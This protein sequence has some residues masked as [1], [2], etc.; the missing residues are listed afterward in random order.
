V[1]A[2]GKLS[3]NEDD[4]AIRS[5]WK[6][7]GLNR[8][9][10]AIAIQDVS[11]C[12]IAL[13][14]HLP[15]EGREREK[16]PVE[17]C[18]YNS[19]FQFSKTR[20]YRLRSAIAMN[21][22]RLS[23]RKKRERKQWKHARINPALDIEYQ[24][25]QKREKPAVPLPIPRR[26]RGFF[27]RFFASILARRAREIGAFHG[28]CSHREI[29][30]PEIARSLSVSVPGENA[31]RVSRAADKAPDKATGTLRGDIASSPR[32]E[33]GESLPLPPAKKYVFSVHGEEWGKR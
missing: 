2:L 5:A 27:A 26:K 30:Y 10:A 25:R 11:A 4:G 13:T 20:R 29:E 21:H 23:R 7:Q 14:I 3:A 9:H 16:A 15:E 6:N 31:P 33:R 1:R 32:R 18:L 24:K 17:R 28:R 12:H 8:V 22:R 19:G